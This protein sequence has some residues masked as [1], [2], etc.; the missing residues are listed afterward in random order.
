MGTNS[1]PVHAFPVEDEDDALG[2]VVALLREAR[3]MSRE[4]L[5]DATKQ[6]DPRGVSPSTVAKLEQG[7]KSPRPRTLAML[8]RALGVTTTELFER[9]DLLTEAKDD[10]GR[11]TW[12]K[13]RRIALGRIPAAGAVGAL[14]GGAIGAAM[15]G[16]MGAVIGAAA[17][18]RQGSQMDELRKALEREMG[19]PLNSKDLDVLKALRNLS[20]RGADSHH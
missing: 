15:A 12:Q 1:E 20:Q 19:R 16:P 8:A 2:R 7:A 11:V 6:D 18:A 3:G 14:A 4:D 17:G 5:A 9:A 13:A 10:T